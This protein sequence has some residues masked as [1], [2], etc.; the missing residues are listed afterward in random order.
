MWGGYVNNLGTASDTNNRGQGRSCICILAIRFKMDD[1]GDL[2]VAGCPMAFL[3][4][5]LK[6]DFG[7]LF[8][9]V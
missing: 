5:H 4:L 7:W 6:T 8:L 1:L 2:F 3:A 9:R